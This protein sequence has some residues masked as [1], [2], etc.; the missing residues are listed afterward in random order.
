MN[1]GFN[2]VE[3]PESGSLRKDWN[4]SL[5][6]KKKSNNRKTHIFLN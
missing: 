5:G 2:L 3:I 4:F 1:Q 6:A